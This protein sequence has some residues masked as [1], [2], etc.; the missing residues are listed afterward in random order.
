M[1]RVSLLITLAMLMLFPL[2]VWSQKDN[3]ILDAYRRNFAIASLDVKIQILQDA[4]KGG[5]KDMGPLYLQAIDFVLDNSSLI[6]TD[7]RFRQL[8]VIAAQGIEKTGYQKAKYSLWK[9][10]KIDKATMTRVA[11]MHALGIVAVGDKEIIENLNEWVKNQ[12]VIFKSGKIPDLQ[13]IA[14]AMDTLGELGDPSSF[15]IVFSAM[16]LGY[17]DNITAKAKKALFKIKGNFKDMLMG[18][19]KNQPLIEKKQALVMALNSDKLKDDEKGEIAQYALDIAL[20]TESR[21][22]L[23]R[24]ISR[25]IRFAA[26]RALSERKWSKATS[27][28]IKHFNATIQE[29][30]RGITDKSHLLEAI[31]CLGNM[32]THEA[33]VRLTQYLVLLNSYTEKGKGY[34]NQI[35]LAVLDSLG[36]LGDKVAFDDLMYTQYLN[37]SDSIKQAAKKALEK[38]KW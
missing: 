10:F 32:G 25:E 27:L 16:N 30:E 13:V 4:T 14:V 37:Y 28:V 6:P 34:D 31:A 7:P 3:K 20:N 21:N 29:Y 18:V 12:N 35:I 24:K 17:S 11:I 2:A 19:I 5:S 8:S 15:P 23:E 26:V 9:L 36:K 38:I 22:S 33:A 1:K